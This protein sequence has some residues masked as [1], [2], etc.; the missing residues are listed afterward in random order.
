MS[1][2][3]LK[4]ITKATQPKM[5]SPQGRNQTITNLSLFSYPNEF[6][7]ALKILAFFYFNWANSV[8]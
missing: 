2:Q 1:F 7:V 5:L 4:V 3:E 8:I 6:C